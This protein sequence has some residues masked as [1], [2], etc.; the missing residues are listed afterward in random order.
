MS[1]HHETNT[2]ERK[3]LVVIVF[4]IITMVLEIFFGFLTGSMALLADGFHMG[5]H[6]LALGL[7]FT[8]Y[9]LIRRF[10]DSPSFPKGT[11][12]IGDLT[13][14]TSSLFLAG[15]GLSV[16]YESVLRLFN[17]RD[18]E[19]NEAILVA[20]VGLIVN[21]VCIFIMEY[22][23][24]QCEHSCNNHHVHHEDFNFKAAY[25]HILADA[26]TSVLAIIAL[27]VGK[28]FNLTYFDALIGA[29]GG[30]LIL[31]WAYLLLK[32]TTLKLVDYQKG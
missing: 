6:V 1:H 24:N 16:I 14:Y 18:I 2:N 32:E 17:P 8:S 10:K 28:Y 31:K 23:G 4:T 21:V 9:I 29:L 19:F 3:T 12:K 7:T 30:V 13:G 22:K 11:N 25:F 15:I 26:L 27:L 5:T 20:F